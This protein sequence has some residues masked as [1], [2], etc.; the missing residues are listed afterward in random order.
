MATSI[1][2]DMPLAQVPDKKQPGGTAQ[3]SVDSNFTP[4]SN[5]EVRALIRKSELVA[6]VRVIS[7]SPA[8]L[9][10]EQH[11][12]KIE[13]TSFVVLETFLGHPPAGNLNLLCICSG[14]TWSGDIK[15]GVEFILFA[16]YSKKDHA[17]EPVGEGYEE[18][19]YP[20]LRQQILSEIRRSR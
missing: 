1:H 7:F 3:Q 11:G 9:E 13:R 6:H 5:S 12:D 20:K 15:P 10:E 19:V 16:R 8:T 18:G 17:W 4:L 14:D 2:P